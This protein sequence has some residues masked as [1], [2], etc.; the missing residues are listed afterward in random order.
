MKSPSFS[1]SS[2]IT[3]M[4]RICDPWITNIFVKHQLCINFVVCICITE[5]LCC[6]PET[7]YINSTSPKVKVF[8]NNVISFKKK[9]WPCP[10]RFLTRA[11][12]EVSVSLPVVQ[13]P[14]ESVTVT[15][16]T[17]RLMMPLEWFLQVREG[18][19]PASLCFRACFPASFQTSLGPILEM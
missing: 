6:T 18:A 5:S 3:R 8:S 11:D 19:W 12:T 9:M 4:L 1:V 14:S 16:Q 7:S 17:M 10:P 2:V 15:Y 13:G